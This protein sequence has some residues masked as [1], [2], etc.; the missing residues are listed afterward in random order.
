MGL[1]SQELLSL[2]EG[3]PPKQ[4]PKSGT[5]TP[6]EPQNLEPEPDIQK[7]KETPRSLRRAPEELEV[8]GASVQCRAEGIREL[9]KIRGTLFGGPFEKDPTT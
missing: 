3:S 8:E 2:Q 9:P 4:P 6:R 1:E 7:R 5:G